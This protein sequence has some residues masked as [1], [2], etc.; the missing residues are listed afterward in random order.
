MG[1][2]FDLLSW[3]HNLI[4]SLVRTDRAAGY[5]E[6]FST[7][8]HFTNCSARLNTSRTVQHARTLHEPFS[9]SEH[10]TNC[11]ARLNT[12]RTVQHARTLHELFSTPERFTNRSAR[13]NASRTVQHAWTLHEPFST[14]EH[15]TNRSACLNTSRTVQHVWTLYLQHL[16]NIM[17]RH[18]QNCPTAGHEDV[19][20]A[21]SIRHLDIRW[22]WAVSF[23]PR[24]P[25]HRGKS[26]HYPPNRRLGG[27]NRHLDVSE[28]KHC[29]VSAENRT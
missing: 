24:P 23:T 18:K 2:Q 1:P 15:F 11:S 3:A 22:R 19:Q 26:L 8:E 17:Y 21:P 9:T 13:P 29:L 7:S 5:H 4:S 25:Y 6:L 10:F 27:P 12:S 16:F 20:G 28:T 14:P